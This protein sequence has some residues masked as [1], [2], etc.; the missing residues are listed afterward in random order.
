[1]LYFLIAAAGFLGA[2]A[3]VIMGGV[4]LYAFPGIFPWGT[5][6]VNLTGS[7]LMCIFMT[8]TLGLLQIR[9]EYRTAVATGFL[10][11]Y[12][13]FSLFTLE[14]FK[15]FSSGHLVLGA[16]YY[17]GTPLT[18][19]IAGWWGLKTGKRII[20]SFEIQNKRIGSN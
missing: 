19:V 17:L 8:L 4:V 13:T 15:L 2:N 18:C 9:V 14:T 20:K 10:G 12:T 11:A 3:R 6:L 5:F 16:L 7:F 1:M